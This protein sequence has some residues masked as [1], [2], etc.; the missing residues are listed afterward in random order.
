MNSDQERS[1]SHSLRISLMRKLSSM[2]PDR[3]ESSIHTVRDNDART[4]PG[5]TPVLQAAFFVVGYLLMVASVVAFFAR[6]IGWSPS[7]LIVGASHL[8]LALIGLPK[9]PAALDTD[10]ALGESAWERD[11]DVVMDRSDTVVTPRPVARI[12][13]PPVFPPRTRT[14]P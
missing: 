6:Y 5:W 4:A 13:R 11:P 9:K 10:V 8:V 7:L 3:E 2:V 14:S 12:V 1:T